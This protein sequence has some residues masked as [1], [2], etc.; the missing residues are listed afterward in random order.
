[1]EQNSLNPDTV[2]QY[3]LA[4]KK[5]AQEAHDQVKTTLAD[6]Y[7]ANHLLIK[8]STDSSIRAADAQLATLRYAGDDKENYVRLNLLKARALNNMNRPK[9]GLAILYRILG[10]A[11]RDNDILAQVRIINGIAGNYVNVGQD[12]ASLQWSYRTLRLYPAPL[13]L[14]YREAYN[15]TLNNIGIA[16]IHGYE[17]HRQKTDLD[18]A[19]Y[20][21]TASI[22]MSRAQGL[23]GGLA[24]ALGLKGN[25]LGYAGRTEEG[26]PLL[27]ESLALYRQ[28]GNRYSIINAI[29]MLGNFYGI[30]QQPEKG[31]AICR[32]GI[33]LMNGAAPNTFLY[34]NLAGNYKLAGRYREYGETMETLLHIKDSLYQHNSAEA[35]SEMQAKYE[36]QKKELII[37]RQKLDITQKKYWLYGSFFLLGVTL[38]AGWVFFQSR[39]KAQRVRLQEMA[40]E[41]KQKTIQAVMQA[42][43]NERKRIAGDLHDSVAQKMVGARMNLEAFEEALP[44]LTAEQ[45]HI[46]ANIFSLVDESCSEVRSIS[47]SMMPQAF[48]QSGLT[49]TLRQFIDRINNKSLQVHLHAEGSLEGIGKDMEMM[50]YRIMQECIQNVLKHARA[51]RLDISIIAENDEIDVTIEDNGV[52]FDTRMADPESSIGMNNIR[53]R[54]AF[55]NGNLDITSQPGMGTLVALYIPVKRS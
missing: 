32:E 26:E 53:S 50:I 10:E 40:M 55:L 51:S 54:V 15:N 13:P 18:S 47:H 5:L 4:A 24:Y 37:V 41:Q 12:S 21:T 45:Q 52:G 36:V 33:A 3:A 35:L 8:G 30:T 27:K 42:E 14:T 7:I 46:Y 6:Y 19:V 31:I 34:G 25:I 11:E 39:K 48:F 2:Y 1:M 9:E 17:T 49:D 38:I 43:E 44:A 22:D 28:I 29:S 16:F 20:Y 23:I